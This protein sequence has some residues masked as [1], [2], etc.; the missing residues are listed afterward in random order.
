MVA[1][2]ILSLPLS[3]AVAVRGQRTDGAESP[4][5]C[6]DSVRVTLYT[7]V[8]DSSVSQLRGANE[9]SDDD[10]SGEY[11]DHSPDEDQI[12]DVPS[13]DYTVFY[14]DGTW[15]GEDDYG[16]FR[17]Q[18]GHS[19]DPTEK[20]LDYDVCGAVLKHSYERY[21][22]KRYCGKMAD[23]Q[24]SNVTDDTTGYCSHHQNRV[25]LEKGH[26]ENAKHLAFVESR[27]DIF[28]YLSPHEQ[29]LAIETFRSL[30]DESKYGYE[31]DTNTLTIETEQDTAFEGQ[32]VEIDFP[33]PTEKTARGK[34]LWFAALDYVRMEN[35]LEEQ[36]R[37]AFEETGPD[38]E[39]L[40]V[41][42]TT[43]IVNVNDDTGE[44]TE[45]TD[46]HH[47]NLPLSRIQ[48]DYERHL[49]VGGV[50]HDGTEEASEQEAREWVVTVEGDTNVDEVEPP[51]S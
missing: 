49:E 36:F 28:E 40:T 8:I 44:V 11:K 9:M 7:T 24:F 3:Y 41:G 46:E 17:L 19:T 20:D 22:E 26:M 2:H 1:G 32:D 5:G 30:L 6:R 15:F 21:G 16:Q 43:K 38:G 37:V 29:I 39:Q 50:E 33:V 47:L 35:I 42:E 23:T 34:A 13:V 12:V 10:S 14:S 31:S 48:K 45:D 4:K 25:N 27:E 51:D 18:A